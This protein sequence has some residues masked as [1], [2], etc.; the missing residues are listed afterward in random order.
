[1]NNRVNYTFVGSFV[2]VGII[3][4]LSLSYW[5]LRPS[6]D[7]KISQFNIY[8]DESVLGLNIDAPVKYRGI[9]VGKVTH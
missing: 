4:I 9:S 2:L 7:A 3:L 1:M 8:F 6:D 5:M